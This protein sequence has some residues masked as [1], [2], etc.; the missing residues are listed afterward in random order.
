MKKL[1]KFSFKINV[2]LNVLEKY[3]SCNVNNMLIFIDSLQFLNSSF[4]SLVKNL[5]KTDFKYFSQE[6][7]SNLLDLVKEKLFDPHEYMSD[8]EKF[9]EELST[10]EVLQFLNR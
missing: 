3:M 1:G 8:F 6:F 2:I 5:D 10:N 7:D 9:K 4:D